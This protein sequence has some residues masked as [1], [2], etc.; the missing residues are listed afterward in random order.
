MA[1]GTR[2]SFA[3]PEGV[4]VEEV[5][6]RTI[7]EFVAASMAGWSF[8]DDQRAAERQTLERA[9]RASPREARFFVARAG[10][11]VVGTS[12]LVLGGE[13]A[14]LA[15]TQVHA[16]HRGR[17]VYRALVAARLDFLAERSV[18]LAVTQAREATAAPILERL[19]FETVF[20]WRCWLLER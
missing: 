1:C 2:R 5:T 9:L 14:Y 18:A 7:D 12:A 15:G 8:P 10:G 11:A 13:H 3:A 4:V 16:S 19:G 20:R 6:E 17:G